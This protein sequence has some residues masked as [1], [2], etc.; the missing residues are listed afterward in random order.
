MAVVGVS[1]CF[2]QSLESAI[3]TDGTE[4]GATLAST[5]RVSGDSTA[6]TE[7]PAGG[8]EVGDGSDTVEPGGE[9][10]TSVDSDANSD[11]T[12]S[13]Q[14]PMGGVGPCCEPHDTP[15]CDDLPGV[16]TCVCELDDFCCEVSWDGVCVDIAVASGCAD[17]GVTMLPDEPGDCCEATDAAGCLDAVVEACVCATDGFCCKVQWDAACVDA[18]EV[19]QC[20]CGYE[21]Q[22]GTSTDTVGPTTDGGSETGDGE[23]GD[24][25]SATPAAGC[26]DDAVE[27]CVCA[28]DAFCC[29][30]AWD[31]Q[32]VTLVN[33][34][35]C[36]VCTYPLGEG[37]CCEENVGAGCD[38]QA[39][40]DCVCAEDPFCCSVSWD[41]VCVDDVD[42]YACGSCPVSTTTAADTGFDPT[43]GAGMT[44]SGSAT[45]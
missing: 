45:G 41:G 40:Q 29:D 28:N 21:A 44:T 36:G 3:D 37:D 14:P 16:S 39:V 8:S 7:H 2:A 26:L 42:T 23:Q 13:P 31:N 33:E 22:S 24:C 38:D 17:C 6:E 15:G 25:C 32:C 19:G 43:G 18:V 10:T 34:F 4:T 9:S 1:G 5:G 27:T 11:S 35:D 20:G 12:S 30:T